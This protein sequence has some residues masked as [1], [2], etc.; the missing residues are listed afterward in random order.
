MFHH[1]DWLV[2]LDVTTFSL[3]GHFRTT[4]TNYW[5]SVADIAQ[6][7]EKKVATGLGNSDGRSMGLDCSVSIS[8]VL[9]EKYSIHNFTGGAGIRSRLQVWAQHHT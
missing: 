9:S 4:S 8:R 6:G 3:S 2:S 1:Y 7:L 5:I